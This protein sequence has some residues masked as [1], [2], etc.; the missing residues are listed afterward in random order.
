[1]S[2]TKELFLTLPDGAPV[3]RY[4]LEKG[5]V[6][7]SVLDRGS[8][9]QRVAVPG[10][11]GRPVEVLLN[12]ADPAAYLDCPD[13]LGVFVGRV[14]N[15]IAK[16]RFTLDGRGYQL[17]CNNGEN[18]LHGGVDGFSRRVFR[19]VRAEDDLLELA[20]TS[21]DGDQGYPGKLELTVRW[22]LLDDGFALE[23]EAEADKATPA[24]FTCHAYWDLAGKDAGPEAVMGHQLR[25]F[26]SR[27]TPVDETLIPT[28]E[29]AAVEG[30]PFDFTAPHAI[31]ERIGQDCPQLA[32]AG[33]YDHNFALDSV[34]G[35]DGL[36]PLAQVTSPAT[37]IT[38]TVETTLPGVQF[39]SGNFMQGHEKRSGFCLEPQT[40]PDAVNQPAFGQDV[41]LRPGE[42]RRDAIRWHFSL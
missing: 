23:W 18:H 27:Y 6:S 37:G 11:G 34:P 30:T 3:H 42:V 32:I 15:R 40:F 14:A 24:A 13:Y 39:Y 17:A 12:Y 9:L 1:M 35:P 4:T 16:G 25:L 33:G 31:G 21:P 8:T 38:M 5:G 20:L 2:V 29:L 19:L 10:P 36:R 22:K 41:I 7:L 28:G 26:A